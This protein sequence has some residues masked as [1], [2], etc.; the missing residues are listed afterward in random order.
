MN[1]PPAIHQ[2][3]EL[4]RTRNSFDRVEQTAYADCNEALLTR[5]QQVIYST[6]IEAV[7]LGKPGAYMAD[8]PAGTGKTFTKGL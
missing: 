8:S 2:Q 6:V 5:E 4:Q 7:T 3:T 1:L